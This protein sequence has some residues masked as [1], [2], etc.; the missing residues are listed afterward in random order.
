MLLTLAKILGIFETWQFILIIAL[1]ALVI[2]LT[3]I[4]KRQQV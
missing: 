2:V 1:L 4:K 3:I